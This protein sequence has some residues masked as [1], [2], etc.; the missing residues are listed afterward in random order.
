MLLGDLNADPKGL[1]ALGM[2]PDLVPLIQTGFTNTRQTKILDNILMDRVQTREFTG[3]AGIISMEKMF[4]IVMKDA[5]RLSDHVP[6]WAEFTI[7][8]QPNS[9][10]MVGNSSMNLV[11]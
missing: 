11:R 8:E 9:S 3:R 1:Q 10:V 4:G 5:E 7:T 2:I 6:I